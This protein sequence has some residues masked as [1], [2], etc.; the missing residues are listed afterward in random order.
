M[1]DDIRDANR[2]RWEA[3]AAS[4]ARRAGTRGIWRKGHRDPTL[5]LH[6]AELKWLD[7]AA[8]KRVAVLGSGDNDV[9]YAYFG[10]EP[11]RDVSAP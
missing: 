11:R 7:D 9:A 2:H 10:R 4:W 5:A 3:A 6:A 8:G 1:V